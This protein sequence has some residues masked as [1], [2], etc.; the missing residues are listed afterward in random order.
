MSPDNVSHPIR[1]LVI[2]DSRTAR[3][4]LVAM[5]E[6]AGGLQVV[7]VGETGEDAVRLARRIHPDI[8]AMDIIMPEMDGLEAT[9]AIMRE[10][11]TPIVLLTSTL[12]YS[13][14][15]LTFEA[16]RLGAL[17]VVNKPP[18]GDDAAW[19][20]VLQTMRLMAK[21]AVVRRWDP[22][23]R[24]TPSPDVP[25]VA[26][27]TSPLP[28]APPDQTAQRPR[29]HIIGIGSST[30]GPAALAT[31]LGALPADFA[32]PILIVQHITKGFGP[33]LAEWL[34]TQT[35]L[36]VSLAG[37]GDTPQPGTVL[38]APDDC[39]LQINAWGIVELC[40]DPPYRGLRPSI[41]YL[42]NSLSNVYGPRAV[43]VQLTG[44]GD[45]GAEGLEKL[46]R[47]GGWVIAQD[48][49]TCVVS[50]MPHE[51]IVRKAANEILAPPQI[52]QRLQT[53]SH[54][55]VAKNMR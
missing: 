10:V 32:L 39:H 24:K 6:S 1:V 20:T 48:E 21:V 28:P 38:M 7:G 46:R 34:N 3:E 14:V 47:H 52:A 43:G 30:G 29:A 2:D 37:H 22:D 42:F 8:I 15:N 55:A 9:R 33:G 45:D 54:V 53:F 5:L 19:E 27:K 11:P 49:K 41:N 50:S 18:V 40:K 51:V 35:A 36:R 23:A 13:D 31:I 44:M 26:P 16:M 17:A 25:A 4:L 12:M